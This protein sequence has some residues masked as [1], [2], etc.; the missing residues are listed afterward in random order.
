MIKDE[1]WPVARLIPV[2]TASGVEAK[3]RC[4]ASALLAVLGAVQEFGRAILRPLGAPAGKVDTYVEV[5]FRFGNATIR[6]DGVITVTRGVRTW[7]AL[8]EVKTG[9]ND[10]EPAQVDAYLDLARQLE[11]D[12]LLTI[13]NQYE[14]KSSDYPVAVDRKK[15]RR[16]QLHHWSWFRVLTEAEVQKRHHGVKDPDQAYML[17]ELIRYLSD[18]RSGIV[19]FGDMGSGWTA[20]REGAR[21]RTLRKV[22]PNV[23][24]VAARW[25]ELI[26]FLALDLTR[27]LGRDVKQVVS[28]AES[29]PAARLQALRDSLAAQG[30]LY[31]E[32]HIPDTVG[33]L[34]I[35]ADLTARQVS[36]FTRVEAPREGRSRGRVSWLLRQ[37]TKSPPGL[38]IEAKLARSSSSLSSQLGAAREQPDLLVPE[39][40]KEI[41]QFV[42]TLTRDM[43][44]NRAAGRG[45][46][47]DSVMA[48]TKT[49]YAEVQ[50]NLNAWRAKP[51]KL[52]SDRQPA[53]LGDG[54]PREVETA[55]ERAQ[56]EIE[57][58]AETPVERP[59]EGS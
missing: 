33:P 14:T 31:A 59:A 27:E 15:L 50:Q 36:V 12:A 17:G 32:L 54:L 5:P 6:P 51:P 58:P 11:F 34:E 37:L 21:I 35:V 38:I 3:E 1:R 49:F 10:L 9:P 45:G 40:D 55:I 2:T 44:L 29:T 20:V 25:D 30:Q 56:D 4:S 42:L 26:R 22:D 28:K 16:V 18:G 19:M 39:R 41:R 48:A 46:F 57:V 23:S 13:S 53:P 47:I 24:E 7:G 43:G 52:P 8:V